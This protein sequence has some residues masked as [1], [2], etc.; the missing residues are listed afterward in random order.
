MLLFYAVLVAESRIHRQTGRPQDVPIGRSTGTIS[1]RTGPKL[2]GRTDP[3][4]RSV[5]SLLGTYGSTISWC[6][7]VQNSKNREAFGVKAEV[8]KISF[9]RLRFSFPVD[10]LFRFLLLKYV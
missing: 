2:V 10:R 6:D 4:S 9:Y 5:P 1:Y 8:G 7:M 3:P